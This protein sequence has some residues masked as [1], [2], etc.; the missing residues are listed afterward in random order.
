[1][2]IREGLRLIMHSMHCIPLKISPERFLTVCFF[3][4]CSK[5]PCLLGVWQF[6]LKK[7]CSFVLKSKESLGGQLEL[8]LFRLSHL[9]YSIVLCCVGGK[10]E[11]GLLY[12]R[13]PLFSGLLEGKFELG[14]LRLL[15]FRTPLFSVVLEGKFEL[16]L[17]RL[18]YFRTP[19]FSVASS[20]T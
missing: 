6:I 16:G 7:T 15:Y 14:L 17:F 5:I 10:I 12:F 8:C 1:M 19:L 9:S 11:L 4:M 3:L 13:A 2:E 18:L 20:V